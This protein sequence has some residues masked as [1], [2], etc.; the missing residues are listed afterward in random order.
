[1]IDSDELSA[2]RRDA[3][4]RIKRMNEQM[5][6]IERTLAEKNKQLERVLSDMHEA[7]SAISFLERDRLTGASTLRLVS[8]AAPSA[9]FAT[10]RAR[11]MTPS[12]LR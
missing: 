3:A 1:M 4:A 9:L 11:F 6:D 12:C 5:A 8:C 2:R 7:E 10:I